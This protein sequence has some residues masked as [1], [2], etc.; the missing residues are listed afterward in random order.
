ME[1]KTKY[2]SISTFAILFNS[3]VVDS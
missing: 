1:I 2:K 3:R